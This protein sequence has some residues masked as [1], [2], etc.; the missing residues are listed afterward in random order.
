MSSLLKLD[1]A[2]SQ[3][4]NPQALIGEAEKARETLEK[5]TGPGAEFLG[6]ID[7]PNQARQELTALK[8]A[9]EKIRRTDALVA[10]GIGGSYLGSRA[11]IE[12]LTMPFSPAF[13]VHFAGHHLDAG[14]HAA[15]LDALRGKKYSVNVISKSGTTTEPGVAFRFF[16]GDLSRRF[17]PAELRDLVFVTTDAKKGGLRKLASAVGLPSFTIADDVGGRFSVL[18]PVGLLPIAAAGFNIEAILDGAREM[19]E[20]VRTKKGLENPALAYA[21]YRNAAYRSGKKIE[22]FVSYRPRL[23]F[24]AE[25]W[26]QLYGESEGKNKKGIYP[27]SV[28][29]TSDLHSMGQW[30]QDGERTIFETVFDV[31]S[32]AKL[33]VPPA[34]SDDDGLGYL[35]GRP[36]NDINRTALKA[37]LQAHDEGGVPCLRIEIPRLDEK[38]IGAVIYFYEYACGV[39]AYMLGVNPFDQPGVE[40]YKKA[41]Y[42]LLGRPGS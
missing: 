27:A 31:E 22:M 9:A 10:V 36:L 30:M 35:E 16:Y 15:L 4:A 14:Y 29:L 25:W 6:W 41:M 40:A 5:R 11:V 38:T 13:P 32:D 17:S 18:S 23:H 2:H 1:F 34:D 19:M 3:T 12:A 28:D 7:L 33:L 24:L 8:E 20:I 21:A 39:S 26:K 42:R 37:T